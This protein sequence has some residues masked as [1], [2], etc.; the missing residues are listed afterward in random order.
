VPDTIIDSSSAEVFCSNDPSLKVVVALIYPG[1]NY[2]YDY[3]L[4]GY[5]LV[6][7][8]CDSETPSDAIS[9]T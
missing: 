1:S 7:Q 5:A 8:S 4:A 9:H 3:A 6:P 2:A